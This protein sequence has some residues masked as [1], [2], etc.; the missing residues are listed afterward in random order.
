MKILSGFKQFILRGN[1]IDLAIGVVIG[2][3]FGAVV[4]SLVTDILTPFIAAVIQ[5]PDFSELFFQ[6]GESKF[7][8]GS[9][10]NAT[11][12]F[13]IVAAVIYFLVLL[14]LNTFM[15]RLDVKE[16]TEPTVKKCPECMSDIPLQARRCAYCTEIV[17]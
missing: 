7:M 2:A 15:N 17:S 1:A 8:Y 16:N 11:L 4:N 9:F 12:S 6:V 10:L 3:A 13:L 14:P 5:V